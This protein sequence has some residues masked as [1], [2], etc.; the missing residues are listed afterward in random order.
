MFWI[1][2]LSMF[3]AQ[4]LLQHPCTHGGHLFGLKSFREEGLGK[5]EE[6]S[7]LKCVILKVRVDPRLS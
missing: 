3:Q 7:A 1:G 4:I 5:T 6:A 2:T